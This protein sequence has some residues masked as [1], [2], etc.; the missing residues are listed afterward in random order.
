L[1]TTLELAE[2]NSSFLELELHF[3][4]VSSS[5][6]QC[7]FTISIEVEKAS[8]SLRPL[9]IVSTLG[10]RCFYTKFSLNR[11]VTHVFADLY[12]P[13]VCLYTYRVYLLLFYPLESRKISKSD[14]ITIKEKRIAQTLF[15]DYYTI[16]SELNDSAEKYSC[17]SIDFNLI[18]ILDTYGNDSNNK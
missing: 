16:L 14:T 9:F 1:I 4:K 6:D 12:N 15:E 11:L 3:Y 2:I 10:T 13:R 18:P 7:P 8:N 17:S 5:S